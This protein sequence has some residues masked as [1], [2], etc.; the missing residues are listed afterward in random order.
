MSGDVSSDIAIARER[1]YEQLV[2]YTAGLLPAE[3][4]HLYVPTVVASPCVWIGLPSVAIIQQGS[5]GTRVRV[6]SFDVIALPDGYEPRQ[7]AMFD[8]LVQAIADA[9]LSLQ[10]ATDQGSR[11]QAFDI[12]G[13]SVTGSIHTVAMNVFVNALCSGPA[14]PPPLRTLIPTS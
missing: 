6:A 3:R 8:D 7:A 9:V 10:Q 14:P 2:A 1:L 13:P 12:G 4:V 5:A 11:P